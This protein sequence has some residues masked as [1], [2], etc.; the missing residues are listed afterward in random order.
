MSSL[1]LARPF[2][3]GF[4]NAEVTITRYAYTKGDH[5]ATSQS[6][7]SAVY[8]GQ[9]RFVPGSTSEDWARLRRESSRVD[10]TLWIPGWVEG[11]Q[12]TPRVDDRATIDG[13]AYQLVGD[14]VK[15]G[16]QDGML[17][18]PVEREVAVGAEA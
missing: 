14:P 10:G 16:G 6:V 17:R 9:G 7:S 2:H 3:T 11:T 4:F 15:E 12:I 5:G 1:G 18:V 13:Q 8:S